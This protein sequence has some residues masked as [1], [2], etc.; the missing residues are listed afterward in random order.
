MPELERSH[1]MEINDSYAMAWSEMLKV[2]A[3]DGPPPWA[4]EH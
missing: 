3:K 1:E 2:A 4:T